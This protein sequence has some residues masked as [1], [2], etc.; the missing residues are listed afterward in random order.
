MG[1]GD[2][3]GGTSTTADPARTAAILLR[4]DMIIPS[5]GHHRSVTRDITEAGPAPL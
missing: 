1:D 4:G 3:T 5:L 2:G